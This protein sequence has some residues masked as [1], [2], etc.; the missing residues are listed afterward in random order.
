M[1][2][3]VLKKLILSFT[4]DIE[5]DLN[6]THCSICPINSK[7]IILCYNGISKTCKSIDE[8]MSSKVFDGKS[9]SEICEKAKFDF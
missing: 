9:L 5:F 6:G 4:Q 7:R 8:V 1:K 2:I 3:Q